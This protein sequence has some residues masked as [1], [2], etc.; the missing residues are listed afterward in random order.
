MQAP[1]AGEEATVAAATAAAMEGDEEAG[2]RE[3]QGDD[4]DAGGEEGCEPEGDGVFGEEMEEPSNGNAD[5]AVGDGGGEAE[6]VEFD[7][8]CVTAIDTLDASGVAVILTVTESIMLT[9]AATP[10]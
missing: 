7:G 9:I 10:S 4:P 5:E 6:R 3:K 8:D 1:S 2:D